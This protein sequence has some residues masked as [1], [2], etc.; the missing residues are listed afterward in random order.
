MQQ[1]GLNLMGGLHVVSLT[2]INCRC[3]PNEERRTDF[4]KELNLELKKWNWF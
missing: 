1:A 4:E 2:S 3:L